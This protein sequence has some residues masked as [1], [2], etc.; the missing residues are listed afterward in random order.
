[1]R[2]TIA[3]HRLPGTSCGPHHGVRVGLQVGNAPV[4]VVDADVELAVW[5][6]EIHPFTDGKTVDFRGRAVH[7]RRGERFI[8]L[9]WLEERG[10]QGHVMFRRAKLQLDGVEREVLVAALE[11]DHLRADLDL[12][13]EDGLPVCAS[14]RPP[15]ITWSAATTHP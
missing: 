5:T 4:A 14:V 8:Y 11:A 12:T 1:V 3:G 6:T 9:V 2:V 13:A 10:R 7:G 15:A